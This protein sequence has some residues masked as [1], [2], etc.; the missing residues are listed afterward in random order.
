MMLNPD[1]FPG[2]SFF[3]NK[4]RSI[5]ELRGLWEAYND[6]MGGPF[7]SHSFVSADKQYVITLD[8]FV[9]AP[10]FDKR[11]YLRQVE[12]ILYTFDWNNIPGGE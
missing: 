7:V 8:A 3:D 2:Y 4:G 12:A 10:R 1:I 6:F 5:V 11:N 9:Y